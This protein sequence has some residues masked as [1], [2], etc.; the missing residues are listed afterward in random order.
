M[1]LHIWCWVGQRD[2]GMGAAQYAPGTI[3]KV[4]A[5]AHVH[6]NTTIDVQIPM[7]LIWGSGHFDHSYLSV[8][9]TDHQAM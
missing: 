5:F 6:V 4:N 2:V 7:G 3:Q 8:N 1:Y 9:Q